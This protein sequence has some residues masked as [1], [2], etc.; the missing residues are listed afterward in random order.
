MIYIMNKTCPAVLGVSF[1]PGKGDEENICSHSWSNNK[2]NNGVET[3]LDITMRCHLGDE[4]SSDITSKYGN[5]PP[6]YI[7]GD[8]NP[9][10]KKKTERS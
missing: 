5:L 6:C 7:N 1:L 10:I 3:D 9:A 2:K 4:P 8:I